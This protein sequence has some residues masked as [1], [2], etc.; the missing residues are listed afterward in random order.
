M[1]RLLFSDKK[2]HYTLSAGDPRLDHARGVLCL[3]AGD[4]FDVGV[5]NGPIGKATVTAV[6][7]QSLTC[8]VDWA[9]IPPDPPPLWLLIGLCRPATARKILTTAPTLGVQGIFFLRS[10]R[11]DP[12]YAR[13]RLWRDGTAHSYLHE[14]LE[15]AFTHTRLPGLSAGL[16]WREAL[17]SLPDQASARCALDVYEADR[18]FSP[19]C[20]SPSEGT[21]LAIGPERGWN[22]NDRRT[23]RDHG[24][25]FFH[26]GPRVL[27]VETAVTIGAWTANC[28]AGS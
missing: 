7:D 4:R 22:S 8:R 3:Q 26:L 2:N 20:A 27:R 23:L 11:T 15:Q 28:H 19:G 13:S 18:L 16:S 12:A 1:N 10:G 9:E 24:F 14:G 25:A 21:V 6:D 17:D 5:L